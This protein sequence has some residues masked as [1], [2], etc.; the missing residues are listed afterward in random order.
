MHAQS[1]SALLSGVCVCVCVC[2]GGVFNENR[3]LNKIVDHVLNTAIEG[4]AL[5][6]QNPC[7]FPDSY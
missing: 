6:L 1:G 4:D 5:F 3:K 2:G 7:K